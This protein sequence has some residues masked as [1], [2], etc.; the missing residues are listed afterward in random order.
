MSFSG[1]SVAVQ[2]PKKTNKGHL[3]ASRETLKPLFYK[4]LG[5]G[6]EGS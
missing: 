3:L 1:G 6:G 4:G 5:Y 2:A